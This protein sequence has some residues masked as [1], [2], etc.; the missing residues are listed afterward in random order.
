[1]TKSQ[2][3]LRKNNIIIS[4]IDTQTKPINSKHFHFNLIF[5]DHN[6]LLPSLKARRQPNKLLSKVSNHNRYK[7]L[8]NLNRDM[9]HKENG[10]LQSL[11][12]NNTKM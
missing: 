7:P 1:M 8:G 11:H 3:H 4:K 10:A 9:P 5:S 6:G 2:R 12:N